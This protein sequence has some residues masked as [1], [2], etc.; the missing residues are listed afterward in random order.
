MA[1]APQAAASAP[2]LVGRIKDEME[3]NVFIAPWNWNLS[4]ETKF[5]NRSTDYIKLSTILPIHTLRASELTPTLHSKGVFFAD[6]F[7]GRADAT[8]TREINDAVDQG[9]E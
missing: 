6:W 7:L 9:A 3:A 8:L 5:R 2:P 4:F 1:S